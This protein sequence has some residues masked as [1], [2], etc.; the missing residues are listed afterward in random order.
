VAQIPWLGP[1]YFVLKMALF[2]FLY[3][4]LRASSP[5]LRY[6]QLMNFGW[7]FLLPLALVNVVLSATLGLWF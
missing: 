6:D 2:L 3:V 7:K 4:W 5:R 1:V